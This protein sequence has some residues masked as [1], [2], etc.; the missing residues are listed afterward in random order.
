MPQPASHEHKTTINPSPAISPPSA[1]AWANS[2]SASSGR[3]SSA[4]NKNPFVAKLQV[5][6][7]P[8]L[9][10]R[11]GNHHSNCTTLAP[12]C[13]A[14]AIELSVLAESTTKIS[15]AHF[16]E[17]RQR[18]RFAASF[19][20]GT[21]TNRNVMFIA[22]AKPDTDFP[23][24]RHRAAHFRDD[25]TCADDAV[26]FSDCHARQ[27]ECACSDKSIRPI[28]IFAAVRGIQTGKNDGCTV[29]R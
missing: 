23:R 22:A 8:I 7:C 5:L 20:I 6:E 29:L 26:L 12:C 4:S 17:A 2:V 11:P 3:S 16:T 27:N 28:V 18:G 9:F 19:L 25:G 1:I 13:S 10:L 24:R 14:I 21:M 15:S